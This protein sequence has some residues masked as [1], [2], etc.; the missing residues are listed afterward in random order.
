MSGPLARNTDCKEA[1]LASGQ[2][3]LDLKIREAEGGRPGVWAEVIENR[4]KIFSENGQRAWE[5]SSG[6]DAFDGEMERARQREPFRF[7]TE[8]LA[9]E[10]QGPRFR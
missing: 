2:S 4:E 3:P 10:A 7:A 5:G 1:T 9:F 6:Q 8:E